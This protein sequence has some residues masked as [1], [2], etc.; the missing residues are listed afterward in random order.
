MKKRMIHIFSLVTIVCLL[1]C[2]CGGNDSEEVIYPQESNADYQS[3]AQP[4]AGYHVVSSEEFKNLANEAGAKV[5]ESSEDGLLSIQADFGY[6]HNKPSV[7]YFVVTGD[8]LVDGLGSDDFIS[9]Y[10]KAGNN[11]RIPEMTLDQEGANYYFYSEIHPETSEFYADY[12]KVMFIKDFNEVI[13]VVYSGRKKEI[14]DEAFGSDSFLN[15]IMTPY[16]V[17]D[18]VDS[19][20]A[21]TILRNYGDVSDQSKDDYLSYVLETDD[22]Y[23]NYRIE[24]DVSDEDWNVAAEDFVKNYVMDYNDDFSTLTNMEIKKSGE[25]YNY[26]EA[27]EIFSEDGSTVPY[28][29]WRYRPKDSQNEILIE[30][31]D[32]IKGSEQLQTIMDLLIRTSEG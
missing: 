32:Y 2:G 10:I 20:N 26:Y 18:C 31:N 3:A 1:V 6:V 8:P 12:G 4:S 19:E 9:E 17:A 7:W 25:N 15:Q 24:S 23:I 21:K 13:E 28:S 14:I 30:S 11:S 16:N 5:E 27:L 22:Y 29:L